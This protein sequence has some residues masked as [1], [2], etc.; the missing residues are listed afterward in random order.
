MGSLAVFYGGEQSQNVRTKEA[1]EVG[2]KLSALVMFIREHDAQSR[3]VNT[4][5]DTMRIVSEAR[6][7]RTEIEKEL[8]SMEDNLRQRL[9]VAANAQ[10]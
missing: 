7:K 9:T 6:I 1:N 2:Q 3:L 10:Y 5:E 4:I 8:P